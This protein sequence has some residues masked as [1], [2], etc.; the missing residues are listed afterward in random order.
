MIRF[1]IPRPSLYLQ[2]SVQ[3]EFEMEDRF[4]APQELV[5]SKHS[6]CTFG[7]MPELVQSVHH[8]LEEQLH[9]ASLPDPPSTAAQ[10]A[11]LR[12]L[13]KVLLYQ[14]IF[15]ALALISTL[16]KREA[17]GKVPSCFTPL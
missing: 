13:A 7:V 4:Y 9:W 15:S 16:M 11:W 14:A 8:K 6:L 3:P 1:C 5:T 10:L 17:S 12:G 2:S